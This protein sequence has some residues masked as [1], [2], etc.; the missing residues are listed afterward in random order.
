MIYLHV[1]KSKTGTTTIQLGLHRNIPELLTMGYLYPKSGIKAVGHHNI[2]FELT[3][4]ESYDPELGNLNDLL[5]E[6]RVYKKKNPK[7]HVIISSEIFL[8]LV[9]VDMQKLA[10]LKESLETIDKVKLILVLRRQ[11]KHMQSYWSML[12]RKMKTTETINEYFD[13]NINKKIHDHDW[14]LK[15]LLTLFAKEDIIVSAFEQLKNGEVFK[16]FLKLCGIQ[17]IRQLTI[18][19]MVNF[20]PSALAL[21]VTRTV[22][23]L[24][25]KLLNEEEKKEL[26]ECIHFVSRRKNWKKLGS[27]KLLDKKTYR[28]IA[29]K[30]NPPNNRVKRMFPELGEHHTY[31]INAEDYQ[32]ADI[33]SIPHEDI[34]QLAVLAFAKGHEN[35][36][37]KAKANQQKA[38]S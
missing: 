14:L 34:L 16:N 8:T 4:D 29:K 9:K 24:Y 32:V 37:N 22:N 38:L 1:G 18:P 28:Q 19:E 26:Y 11:D 20:S 35:P 31:E 6:I 23:I 27:G 2:A 30:F 13:R 7:G 12:V 36:P 21:E 33:S 25:G 15:R 17:Q 3:G 10:Y 5:D